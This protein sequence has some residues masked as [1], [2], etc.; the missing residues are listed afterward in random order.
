[1][2]ASAGDY[3]Y[4]KCPKSRSEPVEFGTAGRWHVALSQRLLS[5]LYSRHTVL[6]VSSEF[7]VV[8]DRTSQQSACTCIMLDSLHLGLLLTYII[9]CWRYVALV[10]V[11]WRPAL[12][13]SSSSSSS[14]A[15]VIARN[16]Q[17]EFL[18]GHTR[19]IADHLWILLVVLCIQLTLYAINF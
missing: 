12:S 19:H 15:S 13:A 9:Q 1:M 6:F 17:K 2:V 10:V 18:I 7:T 3:S 5:F 16:A 14:S 11:P 4:R 8:F